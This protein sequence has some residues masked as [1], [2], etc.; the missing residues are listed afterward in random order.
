MEGRARADG[1]GWMEG[2]AKGG[3]GRGIRPGRRADGTGVRYLFRASALAMNLASSSSV[4][5]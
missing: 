1:T 5:V 4:T 2:R 3:P